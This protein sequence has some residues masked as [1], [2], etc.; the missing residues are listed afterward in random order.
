MDRSIFTGSGFH[1]FT[2]TCRCLYQIAV[3]CWQV[4]QRLGAVKLK[5]L[6]AKLAVLAKVENDTHY[7]GPK[8]WF[9]CSLSVHGV[10]LEEFQY[11]LE[12]EEPRTFNQQIVNTQNVSLWAIHTNTWHGWNDRRMLHLSWVLPY[13][14]NQR[15]HVRVLHSWPHPEFGAKTIL[16]GA[17]LYTSRHYIDF[18]ALLSVRILPYFVWGLTSI[19][20][21]VAVVT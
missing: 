3:Q 9:P 7:S 14:A 16:F 4:H 21:N 10:S 1:S 19:C 15:T 11:A 18:T 13:I 8:L 6:L 12:L 17:V 20:E 5:L 2:P